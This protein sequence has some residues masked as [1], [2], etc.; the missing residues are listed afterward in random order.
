MESLC[1]YEDSDGDPSDD[2]ESHASGAVGG[3]EHTETLKVAHEHVVSDHESDEARDATLSTAPSQHPKYVVSI[4]AF[5]QAPGI[6]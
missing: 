5:G 3:C 6:L 4:Y 2:E 1:N